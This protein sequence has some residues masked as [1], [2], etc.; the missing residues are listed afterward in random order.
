MRRTQKKWPMGDFDLIF[1]NTSCQGKLVNIAICGQFSL[2][3]KN[4]TLYSKC[5]ALNACKTTKMWCIWSK[6]ISLQRFPIA[7]WRNSS[8]ELA[9]NAEPHVLSWFSGD[10]LPDVFP[11]P[12]T[13]RSSAALTLD[14]TVQCPS[15][16]PPIKITD[17]FTLDSFRRDEA[18]K[19]KMIHHNNTG[20]WNIA[21]IESDVDCECELSVEPNISKQKPCIIN[22]HLALNS[23]I[24]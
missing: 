24:H 22:V 20:G 19:I 21:S 17:C 15:S 6:K 5:T 16:T 1:F 3:N 9:L 12:L 23:L 4:D 13:G 10:S 2:N 8:T 11:D 18:H 7:H 14:H